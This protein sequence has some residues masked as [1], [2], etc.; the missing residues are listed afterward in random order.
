M[1][2]RREFIQA[3]LAASVV[4]V[5]FPVAESARVASGRNVAAFS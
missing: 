5:A 1:P 2:S 3:G 4:P